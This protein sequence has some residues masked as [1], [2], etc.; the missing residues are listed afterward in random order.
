[1]KK[2]YLLS[3]CFL[4]AVAVSAQVQITFKVDVNNYDDN[5]AIAENGMRV[6]GTFATLSGTVDGNDMSDWSPGDDY[7]AMTDEGDGIWSI[8]VEFPAEQIGEELLFK[9]VNG[10][11]GTN[12]GL[13]GSGIAT[14]GCGVDDGAGN[15]NRTLTIPDANTGYQFCFDSCK[16]CDGSDPILGINDKVAKEL[17]LSVA[18]NPTKD[19]AQF[20]YALPTREMVTITIYNT[21]GAEVATVVNGT[22]TPG[23]Y[24]M[25][26]DLSGLDNGIYIYRMQVGSRATHG[27]LV[28]Q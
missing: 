22:Q 17:N 10:D 27:Q 28:K 9:F 18:P 4:I 11:W 12:E 13:D 7:S 21:V 19:L 23:S 5:T 8:T 16:T 25:S 3:F 6:G 2:I 24:T 14:G 15:I 20:Y 26:A 1:M